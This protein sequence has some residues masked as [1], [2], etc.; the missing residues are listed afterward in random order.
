MRY[1]YIS[2]N[3]EQKHFLHVKFIRG[4]SKHKLFFLLLLFFYISLCPN[5]AI[6]IVYRLPIS[7][8][9]KPWLLPQALSPQRILTGFGCLALLQV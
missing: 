8:T 9:N 2:N 6:V 3:L 7:A 5:A 1:K 4:Q